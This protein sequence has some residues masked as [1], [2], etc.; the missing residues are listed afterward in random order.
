MV[1]YLQSQILTARKIEFI[2]LNIGTGNFGNKKVDSNGT[3]REEIDKSIKQIKI[4][5]NRLNSDIF[6]LKRLSSRAIRNDELNNY[7]SHRYES[8]VCEMLELFNECGNSAR[9]IDRKTDISSLQL[10]LK[11][12]RTF[13]D[14]NGETTHNCVKI[15]KHFSKCVNDLTVKQNTIESKVDE[16]LYQRF[17][18]NSLK[19]SVIKQ[20]NMHNNNNN[21]ANGDYTIPS[22]LEPE[23]QREKNR[24]LH[25]HGGYLQ[26]VQM[27]KK[28]RMQIDEINQKMKTV[29]ANQEELKL[30]Y[31][32]IKVILKQHQQD[33]D[34]KNNNQMK[35][36]KNNCNWNGGTAMGL[37]R[38]KMMMM[39][40]MVSKMWM[41]M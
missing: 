4:A 27:I 3:K 16:I 12:L 26:N 40:K 23:R 37:L 5:I 1:L 2:P 22:H 6:L 15:V 29:R 9:L 39:M 35:Q 13:L 17:K 31:D 34:E 25:H 30:Q 19:Y 14:K 21:N 20:E 11:I 33:L 28:K 24:L 32:Q 8:D 41:L 7:G 10:R 38:L 18:Q 36:N